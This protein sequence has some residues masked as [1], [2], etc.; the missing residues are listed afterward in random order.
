MTDKYRNLTPEEC[1]KARRTILAS[2]HI[3]ICCMC[4]SADSGNLY[5]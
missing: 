2:A 3:G 1:V 4:N 5:S